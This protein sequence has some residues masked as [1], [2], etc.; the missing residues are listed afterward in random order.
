MPRPRATRRWLAG[1]RLECRRA[2]NRRRRPQSGCRAAGLSADLRL[3]IEGRSRLRIRSVAGKLLSYQDI[4]QIAQVHPKTVQRWVKRLNLSVFRPTQ[5]TVRL[6]EAEAARLFQPTPYAS[7]PP[8]CPPVN[9][10]PGFTSR[11]FN[12]SAPT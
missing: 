5:I 7:P 9:V 3:L 11:K 2:H 4:A 1:R 10:Q 6:S 8:K 12:A